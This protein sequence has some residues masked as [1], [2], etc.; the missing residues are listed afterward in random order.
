MIRSI[1]II[2]CVLLFSC[3]GMIRYKECAK[4]YSIFLANNQDGINGV[5]LYK[6]SSHY[7]VLYKNLSVD[8]KLISNVRIDTTDVLN[9]IMIFC[10]NGRFIGP[11]YF[12]SKENISELIEV[13]SNAIYSSSLGRY[14]IVKDSIFVEFIYPYYINAP[15]INYKMKLLKFDWKSESISTKD[16]ISIVYSNTPFREVKLP[17]KFNLIADKIYPS[18]D[19]T[20][21]WNFEFESKLNE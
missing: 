2:V 1:I 21:F 5:Y 20:L 11:I 15:F 4:K 19:T 8:G 9:S 12:N 17:R 6:D 3:S 14:K 10:S 7:K 16:E 13:K 18:I